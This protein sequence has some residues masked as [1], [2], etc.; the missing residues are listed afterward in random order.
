M[1]TDISFAKEL[2]WLNDKEFQQLIDF[3]GLEEHRDKS[4]DEILDLVIE[5]SQNDYLL[6]NSLENLTKIELKILLYVAG[7]EEGSNLGDVSKKLFIPPQTLEVELQNLRQNGFLYLRRNRERLTNI[8]DKY[9][10]FDHFVSKLNIPIR[11]ERENYLFQDAMSLFDEDIGSSFYTQEFLSALN[12]ELAEST[13]DVLEL[14]FANGGAIP[15]K[16]FKS[17]CK[18]NSENTLN[19]LYEK[20]LGKE[21]VFFDEE[22]F[23]FFVMPTEMVDAWGRFNYLVERGYGAQLEST[24][25]DFALNLKKT[26]FFIQSKGAVLTQAMR[27]KLA[28]SRRLSQNLISE[29]LDPVSPV[30]LIDQLEFIFPLLRMME[31]LE[32]KDYRLNLTNK[33]QEF[34]EKP[35]TQ[36]LTEIIEIIKEKGDKVSFYEE[37]FQPED[38]TFFSQEDFDLVV[39]LLSH[40]DSRGLTWLTA[41]YIQ[42]NVYRSPDYPMASFARQVQNFSRRFVNTVFY[43]FLFGLVSYERKEND[44][45]LTISKI[46]DHYFNETLE[47]MEHDYYSSCLFFNPDLSIIVDKNLASEMVLYIMKAFTKIEDENQVLTLSLNRETFQEGVMIGFPPT[48]FTDTILNCFRTPLPQNVEYFL[49]EW[50]KNIQIASIMRKT[51]IKVEDKE[52]LDNLIQQP[53]LKGV[54]EDRLGDQAAVVAEGQEQNLIT[55]A[56]KLNIIIKLFN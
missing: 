9:Y 49:Q 19:A 48:V 36:I 4:R 13:R 2:E 20:R 55:A 8:R 35:P 37:I 44:I 46:G 50:S 10:L 34:I 31:L 42:E 18:E 11:E 26:L 29:R 21:V 33:F 1:K 27:L 32:V 12:E 14:T 52:V 45:Y 22:F 3:W 38:I 30:K 16:K 54:F 41:Q 56:E 51:V 43:L 28:D 6:R 17:I 40:E 24:G 15:I 39:K 23:R 25:F 5:R 53:K 47:E 7:C